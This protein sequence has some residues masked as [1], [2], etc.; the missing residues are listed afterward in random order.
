MRPKVSIITPSYNRAKIISETAQ[1]IFRQTYTNWEWIIVDDGSTDDSWEVINAYAI[2]DPRISVYKRHREPKGA[3]VCR[4]IGVAKSTGDF[5]MFLDTDDL[6]A[7]FC[8]EQRLAAYQINPNV[9]FI[10]FPMLL[11]KNVPDDLRL[12]WNVDSQIDDI[13]RI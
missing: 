2:Q 7:S 6:L 4:N 11:F 1:S 8:I 13:E 9:D 10:V 3:C 5:L 12:L